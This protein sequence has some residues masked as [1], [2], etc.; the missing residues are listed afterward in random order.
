MTKIIYKKEY[1]TETAVLIKRKTYG[2]FGDP[3]GYEEALYQTPDGFYFLY[4]CGGTESPYPNEDIRRIGKDKAQLW[5]DDH[6]KK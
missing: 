5:L 1:N 3:A 4:V 2:Y 6:G